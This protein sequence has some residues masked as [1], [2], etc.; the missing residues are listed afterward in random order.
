[1]IRDAKKPSKTKAD[2][3]PLDG[4]TKRAAEPA[5]GL[6]VVAKASGSKATAAKSSAA[7]ASRPQPLPAKGLGKGVIA[8]APPSFRR[9][10]AL[11]K[12][13]IWP[14]AGCDEAGRGPLAGPVV[15]AA[16]VL[17][18]K[19]VPKG[20][21]DSKRLSAERREELFEE[22]CATA[23]VSVVSASPERINRDNILRASL[24]ALTRAVHAL[25]DLPQ[26]VF[27]DGRDRLAT[28]C[29]SEA[30]IGGDGLIA[31][32]AAASIIAKVTRDRLMCRLAQ[33]CPGYGFE[34][35]KG[36]GVPEHLAALSRLGPTVHHRRF[37]APV[38]AAWR[39]I[40]GIPVELPAGSGD[41]F[42]VAAETSLAASA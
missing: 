21:D 1:M 6:K 9:E 42:E 18:P 27:V 30:V 33:Q 12:K 28:R 37:F 36:Y 22:I 24:W 14:V 25:P 40:E 32:I 10:R 41:L 19:R 26:H 39:K 38:A 5:A 15:A 17:D 16:V 29:E 3:L 31:S 11:I 20:L 7:K 34:S 35:H 23:Q 2:S 4:V 8:V 13:G